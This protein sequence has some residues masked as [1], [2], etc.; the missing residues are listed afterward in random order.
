VERQ[1]KAKLA[2]TNSTNRNDL[3][4][5]VA[6]QKPTISHPILQ[7]QRK[8]GNQAVQRLLNSGGIQAKLQISQPRDAYEQEADRVAD[9]V[10]RM[11][12]PRVQR[13][14]AASEAGA[15]PCRSCG[16]KAAS[17]QCKADHE[18]QA[19]PVSAARN[20]FVDNLGSGR[21][22]DRETRAFFESRFGADLGDA[23]VHSGE[24]AA[25]ISKSVNAKAFTVGRSIAFGSGEYAPGTAMGRKLLAH[26]LTHVLQQKGGL[27]HLTSSS[28]G[29]G[30]QP[31][32]AFE[33]K[34]KYQAD[35]AERSAS[36]L[37]TL[38]RQS[39][40]PPGPPDLPDPRGCSFDFAKI[41]RLFKGDK[42]VA[43]EV[44]NCC[45][46]DPKLAICTAEIIEAARKALGLSEDR[47]PEPFKP[48]AGEFKGLCCEKNKQD[49]EHCC[50]NERAN[51]LSGTC[52]PPR[53][54]FDGGQCRSLNVPPLPQSC[55]P[56]QKTTLGECCFLPLVP[57][58]ALCGLPAPKPPIPP[59]PPP[60]PFPSAVKIFFGPDKPAQGASG[61]TDLSQNL[62]KD[63][64][65]NFAD[66]VRQLHE[67]SQLKVQLVGRASPE[68]NEDYNLDLGRRRA[69]MIAGA[70]QA[71]GIDPNRITDPQ[72]QE[73]RS[74]CQR[75][76]AGV[77]TCGEAGATGPSDRQV[78]ARVFREEK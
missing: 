66:L 72:G 53:T 45:N 26:E 37:V 38:Q 12:D 49:A 30:V 70:L 51:L 17:G 19:E 33:S 63:G 9:Q 75:V 44:L 40:E 47:C 35:A 11:P 31:G 2:K 20:N 39:D 46:T 10:M 50:S 62:T 29:Y 76:R 42:T 43:L 77:F 41:E 3:Q 16:G 21:A 1:Q 71:K 60:T 24:Q 18:N 25:A 22:L 4:R 13:T 23:R 59:L 78:L 69:E 52:C 54:F 32:A 15:T 6:P 28:D 74:E 68:G 14:C 61:S 27:P 36:P 7:L 56:S 64:A 55:L 58:G 65:E 34:S 73:L 67:N 8:I 48:G 57:Q 5:K